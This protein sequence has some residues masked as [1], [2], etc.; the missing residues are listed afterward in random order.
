[1]GYLLIKQVDD[2]LLLFSK[3]SYLQLLS[4]DLYNSSF[5]ISHLTILYF[6][7]LSRKTQNLPVSQIISALVCC[8]IC[9]HCTHSLLLHGFLDLALISFYT[10][11]HCYRPSVRH[12]A[13]DQSKTVEVRIMQ[14]SPYSSPI[15]LVFAG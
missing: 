10:R 7:T 13:V 4:S 15:P 2:S 3:H 9:T 12:T 11:L 6:F 14:F 5:L 8:C 1:L